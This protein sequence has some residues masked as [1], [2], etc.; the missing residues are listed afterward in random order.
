VTK[1]GFP[2]ELR[3]QTIDKPFASKFCNMSSIHE[4]ETRRN[5]MSVSE[6][7]AY[8][9]AYTAMSQTILRK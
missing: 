8:D 2:T 9:A 3:G 1:H 4:Q 7:S 5:G 6:K